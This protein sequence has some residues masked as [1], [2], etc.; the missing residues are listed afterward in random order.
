MDFY[1]I[2]IVNDVNIVSRIKIFMGGDKSAKTTK[3][4]L[5]K[6]F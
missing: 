6:T 1:P 2:A 5:R 4:L 3:I